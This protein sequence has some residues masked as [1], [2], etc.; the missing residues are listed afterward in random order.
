MENKKELPVISF[1]SCALWEEWL[2]E[3]HLNAAR[4]MPRMTGCSV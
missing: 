1:E 4:E 2:G 3:N